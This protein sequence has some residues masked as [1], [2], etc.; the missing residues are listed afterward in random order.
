MVIEFLSVQAGQHLD[1]HTPQPI[2]QVRRLNP[3]KEG[4]QWDQVTQVIS[5]RT[6]T[7]AQLFQLSIR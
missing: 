6:E 5:S 3:E 2:S 4:D 7:K 1:S